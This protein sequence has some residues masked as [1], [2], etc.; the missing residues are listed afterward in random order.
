[1]KLINKKISN[2]EEIINFSSL[3]VGIV[4]IST[5]PG[6]GDTYMTPMTSYKLSSARMVSLVF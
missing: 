6:F 2:A 4:M 1:M 5:I 3:S